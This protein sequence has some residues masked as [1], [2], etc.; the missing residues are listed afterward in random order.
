M[1]ELVVRNVALGLLID[2]APLLCKSG[3][4]LP[5]DFGSFQLLCLRVAI[6]DDADKN[7][8]QEH[9]ECEVEGQEEDLCQDGVTAS[10]LA[11]LLEILIRRNLKTDEVGLGGLNGI[12]QLIYWR[13]ENRKLEQGRQGREEILVTLINTIDFSIM[14]QKAKQLHSHDR[15]DEEQ[16][17]SKEKDMPSARQDDGESLEDLLSEG[18]LVE[19]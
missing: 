17:A 9:V 4:E 12:F 13:F 2:F 16:Y 5:C 15:V 10:V 1:P 6:H 3:D 18:N 11:I 7:R 19:H 14:P 8:D